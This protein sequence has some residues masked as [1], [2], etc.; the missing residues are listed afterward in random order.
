MGRPRNA[1]NRPLPP[2]LY[3]RSDGRFRFRDPIN[4]RWF[5]LGRNEAA[6]IAQANEGN[7]FLLK[8][9]DKDRLL[10]HMQ[11][12]SDTLAHF[13]PIYLKLKAKRVT[14]STLTADTNR[15]AAIAEAIGG[16][17]VSEVTT[18][19]LNEFLN[20]Y[21][22]KARS[23][24]AVRSLLKDIFREAIAEGWRKDNPVSV[25]RSQKVETRR[26]R[27]SLDEFAAIYKWSL[28]HQ[29]RFASQAFALALVTAQRREDVQK[30]EYSHKT[31][32]GTLRVVQ[33][34]TGNT[35]FVPLDLGVAG[36]RLDQI[37]A[38]TQD[39]VSRYVLHHSTRQGRAGRGSHIRIHTLTTAFAEA[40]KGAGVQLDAPVPASFHEI[41]SLSLRLYAEAYGETFAKALAGH[42]SDEMVALY[43]D[44]RDGCFRPVVAK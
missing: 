42:K 28:L 30:I 36:F 37:I 3:R 1:K 39:V 40:R 15:C 38:G 20:R 34:K 43:Q 33:K 7:L 24:Q 4:G 25:T 17:L 10:Q 18:K 21:E 5:P 32:D 2:N 12:A 14:A 8:L 11:G 44:K 26:A 23:R 16:T 9:L 6:A 22:G 29:P 27:L 35:V 13:I 31:K 19:Q 41:R